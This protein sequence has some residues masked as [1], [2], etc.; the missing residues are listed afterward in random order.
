VFR[1]VVVQRGL[2]PTGVG[3]PETALAAAGLPPLVAAIQGYASG[4]CEGV[5]GWLTFCAEAVQRGAGYGV[6]VAD[7]VLAGRLH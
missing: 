3:S 5:A 4:T 2:D 1:A 6:E 7:A